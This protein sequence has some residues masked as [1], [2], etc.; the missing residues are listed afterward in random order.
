VKPNRD[1]E[2]LQLAALT[3]DKARDAAEALRPLIATISAGP[4][5]LVAV[6]DAE[7]REAPTS[8]LIEGILIAPEGW[9]EVSVRV[10]RAVAPGP[11]TL[12]LELRYGDNYVVNA[13]VAVT[14]GHP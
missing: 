7:V 2:P 4:P 5:R 6:T 8:A 11:Y 14:V 1:V 3:V 12:P 9:M 10:D 13:E